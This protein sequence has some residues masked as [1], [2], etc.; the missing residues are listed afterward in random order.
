[1]ASSDEEYLVAHR[2]KIERRQR[3]LTW[4]SIV[5]FFGSGVFAIVPT[6][7]QAIQNPK[8]VTSSADTSLQQ[9]A[10]GFELVLQREPENQTALEGLVKI[11]LQL[12]D[13]KGAIAPLEK[14]VKLNPE[15]QNYKVL[16]EELKKQVGSN[17]KQ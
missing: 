12:G 5:S 1:M 9:Q 7:Q 2:Q 4:V 14:L 17:N 10:Q 3:I 16:L 8:P 13:I 11:R 15:R 6:L